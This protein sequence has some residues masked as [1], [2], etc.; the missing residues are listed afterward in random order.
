MTK[1]FKKLEFMKA[2][3]YCKGSIFRL[4][5]CWWGRKLWRS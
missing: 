2:L 1:H 3:L 4:L 5:F